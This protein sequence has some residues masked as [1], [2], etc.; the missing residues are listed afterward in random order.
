MADGGD[1]RATLADVLRLMSAACSP[2]DA[3]ACALASKSLRDALYE[4]HPR[5]EFG[6]LQFRFSTAMVSC[7]RSR[8]RL[9]WSRAAGLPWK[10][11]QQLIYRRSKNW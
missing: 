1:E 11:Y 8:R 7:V 5:R 2:N 4:L 9:A 6:G 10:P 3:L